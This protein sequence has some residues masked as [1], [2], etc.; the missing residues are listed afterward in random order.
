MATVVVSGRVD[1]LT[2]RL[3]ARKIADAGTTP[4]EVIRITWE[5]IVNTGLVPHEAEDPK[6]K[7]REEAF[8]EL[9]RVREVL[10]KD[11]FL[12]TMTDDQMRDLI[13][14]GLEEKYGAL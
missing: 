2:A 14:E 11:E 6:A 8:R 1:P 7:R 9:E 10:A 13:V 12:A 4:G 3:A 5:N